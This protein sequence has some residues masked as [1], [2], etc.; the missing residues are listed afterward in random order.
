VARRP[1]RCFLAFLWATCSAD[2]QTVAAIH[3]NACVTPTAETAC[4]L[5][6]NTGLDRD[7]TLSPDGRSVV[8]VCATPDRLVAGPTD[9]VQATELWTIRVDHTAP[10]RLLDGGTTKGT[11]GMPVAHFQS[12][13]FSPDGGRIYFLSSAAVVSDAI[14]A[15]DIKTGRLTEVCA[16]NSLVVVQKGVYSG[17]LVVEQHRYYMGG[18]SYDWVYVIQPDGHEIG[19]L[20]DASDPGFADRLKEIGGD[21]GH[22]Q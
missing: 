7:P 17:D 12:P 1:F 16:G 19:A 9:E 10:R 21:D 20:G 13:Q 5:L 14:Y 22:H 18:G 6:T 2:A 11:N 8:F 3:G 15:L 4:K